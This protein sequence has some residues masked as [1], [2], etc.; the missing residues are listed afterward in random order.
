[1]SLK[2]YIDTLKKDIEWDKRSNLDKILTIILLILLLASIVG[3]IYIIENPKQTEYF[4]EFYILGSDGKA[5]NY[6]T[7]L[8]VGENGTVII[9]VVNHEGRDVNYFIEIYL[10][11]MTYININNTNYTTY[12][13]THNAIIHDIRL[14]NKYNITLPPK[15]IVVEGNWT[16]QWETNY[17]FNINE[18]GKWQ[19]WFLLFKDNISEKNDRQK[20]F[21]AM[22]GK[23][24]ILSLKLNVNVMEV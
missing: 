7:K 1:M 9:G 4:T 8:F 15:P 3:T 20:I 13:E 24:G 14:M 18:S 23:N 17:I 11:N 6:P 12:N 19:I 5:Y 22:D 10:V 16:S 21:D 2:K